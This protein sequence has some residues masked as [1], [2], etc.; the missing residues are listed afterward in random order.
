[1]A[2]RDKEERE[3]TLLEA[4]AIIF[5]IVSD[6]LEGYVKAKEKLKEA[7]AEMQR[8]RYSAAFQIVDTLGWNDE[9]ISYHNLL[10]KEKTMTKK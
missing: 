6:E 9:F 3:Y 8:Q 2:K 10:Q 5:K 7:L 4:K 1:M